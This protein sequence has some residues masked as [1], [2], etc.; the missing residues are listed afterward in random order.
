MT[1]HATI[2]CTVKRTERALRNKLSVQQGEDDDEADG[3]QPADGDKLWGRNKRGYYGADTQDYEVGKHW[4]SNASASLALLNT[5]A[6][7]EH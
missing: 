5:P 7:Q 6:A 4:C 2:L 3:A 1:K